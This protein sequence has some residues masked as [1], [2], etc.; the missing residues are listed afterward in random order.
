MS[1]NRIVAIVAFVLSL[2]GLIWT[3]AIQWQS[4]VD[5]VSKQEEKL[6]YIYGKFDVPRAS[7]K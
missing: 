4:L 1:F 7:A 5:R 2:G 3:T 6:D